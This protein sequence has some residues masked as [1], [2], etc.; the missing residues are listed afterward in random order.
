MPHFLYYIRISFI[1]FFYKAH[2]CHSHPKHH[3]HLL[4][5]L[6]L[7]FTLYTKPLQIL[8]ATFDPV[9]YRDCHFRLDRRQQRSRRSRNVLQLA[10][11]ARTARH[12]NARDIMRRQLIHDEF[13]PS[14][15]GKYRIDYGPAYSLWDAIKVEQR[16]SNSWAIHLLVIPVTVSKMADSPFST[17]RY[18]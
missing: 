13:H 3:P 17:Y 1:I 9:S 8:M 5:Y 2:L 10:G 7:N 12:P 14:G 15:A 4:R 11:H 6:F 18:S 16:S